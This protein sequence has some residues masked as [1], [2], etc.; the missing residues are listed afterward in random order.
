MVEHNLEVP[1]SQRPEQQGRR[2]LWSLP[3]S[4]LA[5]RSPA[6]TPTSPKSPLHEQ[7]RS[8]PCRKKCEGPGL[9]CSLISNVSQRCGTPPTVSPNLQESPR[10]RTKINQRHEIYPGSR[11]IAHT[12]SSIFPGLYVTH[13]QQRFSHVPSYDAPSVPRNLDSIRPR[14]L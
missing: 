11:V 5:R 9:R 3:P 1:K 4:S 10:A 2:S 8:Q 14:T 7:S 6:H 12:T 13:M